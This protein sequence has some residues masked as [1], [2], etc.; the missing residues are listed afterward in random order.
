[1][2]S[3]CGPLYGM[4][5]SLHRGVGLWLPP[6]ALMALIF[7]LSDQP[8]LSSGLGVFD[9]VARKIVHVATY[10]LLCFLL[11]RPLRTRV[12][13]Q[14]AILLAF[15]IAAAYAAT[16]EFHQTFVEG[17]H[18]TPVDWLIDSAGAAVVALRL[19]ALELARRAPS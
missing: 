17:R 12:G 9:L 19:R 2:T 6:F 16:D 15:A 3:T 5:M 1:M 7:V 18:G 4:P 14:R 13:P 10:G 8:D 11:W